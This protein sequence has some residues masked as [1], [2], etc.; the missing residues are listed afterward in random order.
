M[1]WQLIVIVL[2]YNFIDGAFVYQVGLT[3]YHKK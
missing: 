2:K 3:S 1:V